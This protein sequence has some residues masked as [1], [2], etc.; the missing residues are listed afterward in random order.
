MIEMKNGFIDI[1]NI[2]LIKAWWEPQRTEKSVTSAISLNFSSM[3]VRR[4]MGPWGAETGV[5]GRDLWGLRGFEP[6]A[7]NRSETN[8]S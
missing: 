5:P 1:G 3:E 6:E 2:D 4:S 8:F 7:A